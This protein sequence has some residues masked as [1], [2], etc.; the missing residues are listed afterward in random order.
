MFQ[1]WWDSS[2]HRIWGVKP[3][4]NS[5]LFSL[6]PNLPLAKEACVDGQP[7]AFRCLLWFKAR[8][9]CPADWMRPWVGRDYLAGT[10]A[11]GC[12]VTQSAACHQESLGRVWGKLLDAVNVDKQ[13]EGGR[14]AA[15]LEMQLAFHGSCHHWIPQSLVSFTLLLTPRSP[16]L[17]V[18]QVHTPCALQVLSKP[19]ALVTSTF[20]HDSLKHRTECN[21]SHF[22]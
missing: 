4:K 14:K 20:A 7:Q 3:G 11:T 5:L 1:D 13:K 18:E 15:P 19:F 12:Q 21:L 2:R 16:H 9:F 17:A 10:S 8:K 22:S 6:L